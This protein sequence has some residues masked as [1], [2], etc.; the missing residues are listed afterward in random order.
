MSLYLEYL[1]E[2]ASREKEL[3]LNPSQLIALSCYWKLLARLKIL[4]MNI[5]KRH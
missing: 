3:G 2:I 1:D 5:V 4:R